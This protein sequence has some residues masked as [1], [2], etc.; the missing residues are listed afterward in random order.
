MPLFLDS[1]AERS[2]E[3]S[4]L[5]AEVGGGQVRFALLAQAEPLND[6]REPGLAQPPAAG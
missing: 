4:V 2:L 1:S 5:H 6:G 3:H